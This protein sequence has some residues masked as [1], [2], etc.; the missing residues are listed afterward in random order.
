MILLAL[1]SQTI[2]FAQNIDNKLS[3]A[4]VNVEILEKV[5]HVP[6][7]SSSRTLR[8][9]LPPSY[10]S[11]NKQYPVIYMLDGQNLFDEQT[12]YAGEW[13][14]DEVLNHFSKESKREVI[15]VGIDNHGVF[16][17]QEYNVVDHP[18]FGKEQGKAFTELLVDVIKPLI[19]KR[20]R[21][22]S[23]RQNTAIVGS[24]MGGLMSFYALMTYPEVFSMAGVY[25]PAF[26]VSDDIYELHKRNPLL[27]DCKIHMLVGSEEG[28]MVP[29]FQKMQS[30]LS[31]NM[32]LENFVSDI[33]EGGTH[34]EALWGE[35][36][37][38]TYEFFYNQ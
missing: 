13:G 35:Q 27:E 16:R 2:L 3:T 38:T 32:P 30:I 26:W 34:G 29:V 28:G 24:S 31:K 20:Y 8:I 17:M 12:A 1:I 9:Y 37:K 15:V 36:F 10:Q 5:V 22:L 11:T 14:V 4:V 21:T 6:Y 25:S 33:I 19:D 7:S 18:E 23:N